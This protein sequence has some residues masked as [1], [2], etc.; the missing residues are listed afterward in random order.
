MAQPL[1]IPHSLS[2]NLRKIQFMVFLTDMYSKNAL[3]GKEVK[4]LIKPPLSAVDMFVSC[5]FCR[6]ALMGNRND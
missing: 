3:F 5:V 2:A 1:N 4:S 6:L